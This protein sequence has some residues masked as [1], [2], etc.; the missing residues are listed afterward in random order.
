[1]RSLCK[2]AWNIP[3]GNPIAESGNNFLNIPSYSDL[4]MV[5]MEAEGESTIEEGGERGYATKDLVE[6]FTYYFWYIGETT[7]GTDDRLLIEQ[8]IETF[9]ETLYND[10]GLAGTVTELEVIEVDTSGVGRPFP[11]QELP[12]SGIQVGYVGVKFI[13]VDQ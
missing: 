7:D 9:I 1:M 11:G 8:K 3:D 10:R 12:G 4:P 13:M 6:E 2:T 5:L